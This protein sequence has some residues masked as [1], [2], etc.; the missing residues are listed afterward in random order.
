[1]E[2]KNLADQI[3]TKT[4]VAG[5]TDCDIVLAK[6]T[7]KSIAYRFGKIEDV[8]ESS[9]KTFGIRALIGSKQSFVSSS[10]FDVKNIDTLV[11]K[12]VEMAKLAPEDDTACLGDPT[13]LETNFI[14]LDLCQN[15]ETDT[16]LMIDNVKK[17]EDA[18]LSIKGI[19]NS[20]GSGASFGTSEFFFSNKPWLYGWL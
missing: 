8:E 14:D 15:Y 17:C 9:G 10:N 12:V 20:E 1:M 11:T 19:S 16:N 4:K 3:I 7:S 5:A 18:A 13:Q 2:F 6:G